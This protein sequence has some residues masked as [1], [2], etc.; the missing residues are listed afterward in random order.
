MG[1]RGWTR[2]RYP[3]EGQVPSRNDF[4]RLVEW[5]D[6]D[7]PFGWVKGIGGVALAVHSLVPIGT[8]HPRATALMTGEVALRAPDGISELPDEPVRFVGTLVGVRNPERK[9]ELRIDADTDRATARFS[10][11]GMDPAWESGF[12]IQHARDE[13]GLLDSDA[14]RCHA[15]PEPSD[16][17]RVPRQRGPRGRLLRG[18]ADPV[19]HAHR[20]AHRP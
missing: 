11:P 7:A 20:R 16:H 8:D 4:Q 14:K 18:A 19:A 17:R 15:K 10:F 3:W 1:Y 13:T 2:T 5:C 12:E 9:W 6:R